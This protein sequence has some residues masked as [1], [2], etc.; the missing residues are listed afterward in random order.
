MVAMSVRRAP[1]A[2]RRT[3]RRGTGT[4][5]SLFGMRSRVA[6]SVLGSKRSS[7]GSVANSMFVFETSRSRPTARSL[8][9][10][11]LAPCPADKSSDFQG[12]EFRRGIVVRAAAAAAFHFGQ[13]EI[14]PQLL[15]ANFGLAERGPGH[16]ELRDGEEGEAPFRLPPWFLVLSLSL[17]PCLQ[18]HEP[19]LRECG[20]WTGSAFPRRADG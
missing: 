8:L 1:P 14:D 9:T 6:S 17:L 5:R 2:M 10:A 13:G 3:M 20:R 16:D 7:P 4:R 11:S 19:T 15:E 18:A 12:R